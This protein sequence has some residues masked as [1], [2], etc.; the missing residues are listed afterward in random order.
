LTNFDKNDPLGTIKREYASNTNFGI[1]SHEDLSTKTGNDAE[2]NGD[3]ILRYRILLNEYKYEGVQGYIYPQQQPGTTALH[4]YYNTVNGD[5][6]Y[7][8]DPNEI[9]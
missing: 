6:F 3:Y 4:R 9:R 1:G 2:S 8:T 5:H 7:T